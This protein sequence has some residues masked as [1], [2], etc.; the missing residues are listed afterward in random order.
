MKKQ[1]LNFV[2]LFAGAGGL[3]NGLEQAGFKCILGVDFDK[4]AMITFKEN[5]KHA[6]VYTEDIKDLTEEKLLQLTKGQKISLVC[7]GPPCQGLS[8]VGKGIPDDSRNYLFKHFVRLVEV[9]NPTY[10]ILENVTGIVGRKNENILQGILTEFSKIGYD[11]TPKVLSA[12]FYG[13]PQKR[14]RTIFIGNNKGYRNIHPEPKF[15]DKTLRNVGDIFTNLKAKD[16]K[17]YNHNKSQAQI[18]KE[19][20]LQRIRHIPEGKSIR[21]KK[22]EDA[23]LP[24]KLKLGIDWSEIREGRLR[25]EKYKRLDRKLPS[26]TIMTDSHTYFHPTED[27]YLTVREAASIQSFPNNFIFH[28]TVTQQWRQIGNAVPT[29]LAKAIGEAI[30]EMDS[31]KEKIEKNHLSVSEIRSQAFNYKVVKKINKKQQILFKE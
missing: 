29:L 22:D 20:D 24:T 13:V 28:G 4:P 12:H 25:Q 6:E 8:T 30:L 17:I 15:N 16:G 26:Q 18:K 5:H 31:N 10:V 27:R 19:L 3:S 1:Q 2:D 7:G 9:L 14:R 23:Y 11:L 21:Y